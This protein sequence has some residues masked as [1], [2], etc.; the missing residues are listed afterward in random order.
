MGNG[1]KNITPADIL[2][3]VVGPTGV[4]KSRLINHYT[5][6]RLAKTS[7][8]LDSCTQ[9]LE[10]FP[11]PLEGPER[12]ILVDTPGFNA[13]SSTSDSKILDCIQR[14]WKAQLVP[15]STSLTSLPHRPNASQS[16]GAGKTCGG[17]I[18]LH[19]VDRQWEAVSKDLEG[20]QK[21]FEKKN[22]RFVV[23]APTSV[24]LTPEALKRRKNQ[25]FGADSSQRTE[26]SNQGAVV[27]DRLLDSHASAEE[28][29]GI[30]LN[31]AK[32]EQRI[33]LA[34]ELEEL[35]KVLSGHPRKELKKTFDE[36]VERYEVLA[37]CGAALS[38]S[39]A[40]EIR[41]KIGMVFGQLR[42]KTSVKDR[43]L[44]IFGETSGF[45]PLSR[46]QVILN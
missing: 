13:T 9:N 32:E 17:L 28:L 11:I 22:L 45:V 41:A 30:A 25:N 43:I 29:V 26:L 33:L 42:G 23:F 37:N 44:K 2:V 35:G 27:F 4:G 6:E 18:Y 24:S 40:A 34:E 3:F 36:I 21:I 16:C 20:L 38:T 19:D 46:L 14:C 5:N 15:L 1:I 31:R 10:H 39:E 12:L 7:N 8:G